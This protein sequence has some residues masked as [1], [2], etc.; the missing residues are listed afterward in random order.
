MTCGSTNT[1]TSA[2][3]P[4]RGER[5]S[6]VLIPPVCNTWESG[7]GTLTP[8]HG[9]RI[10]CTFTTIAQKQVVRLP[11]GFRD[12]RSPRQALPIQRADTHAAGSLGPH[13]PARENVRFPISE[14]RQ[15][16]QCLVWEATGAGLHFIS[17]HLTLPCSFPAPESK[18][19]AAGRPSRA[20]GGAP[21]ASS[22]CLALT[23]QPSL[24]GQGHEDHAL[25]LLALQT[26]GHPARR[27]TSSVTSH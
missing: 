18:A 5:I 3:G 20:Q 22:A 13:L 7:P 16:H 17:P 4:Q 21:D 11:G 26:W 25:T 12:L 19:R 8:P 15:S 10:C 14:R 27:S 1:L 23:W 9:W 6:V 2:S 24:H